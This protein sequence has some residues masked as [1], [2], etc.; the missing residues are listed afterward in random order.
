[1][2]DEAGRGLG[3]GK[4]A[5]GLGDPIAQIAF[6][7][8]TCPT[9]FGDIVTKLID[10]GKCQEHK[11]AMISEDSQ[12]LG[13]PGSYRSV[14]SMDCETEDGLGSVWFSGFG[15]RAAANVAETRLP[16][17]VELMSFDPAEGVFNYYETKGDG[18]EFFGDSKQFITEG[19]GSNG[20]ARCAGCHTG[21]ALIMKELATPWMHWTGDFDTPGHSEIINANESL[22]GR[23]SDGIELENQVIDGNDEWNDSRLEFMRGGVGGTQDGLNTADGTRLDPVSCEISNRYVSVTPVEGEDSDGVD[24]EGG[25]ATAATTSSGFATSLTK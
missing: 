4:I 14:T 23:E 2:H 22:L 5:G 19:A 8:D 17:S 16:T 1:M 20:D 12:L 3:S 6:A 24:S 11:T 7:G 13:E 10:S 9:N 21:G 25:T 15:I 18:I